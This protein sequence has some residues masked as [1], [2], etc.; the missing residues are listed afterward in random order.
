MM[1]SY[2][3]ESLAPLV[4]RFG[5]PFGSQSSAQDVIFPLPSAGAGLVRATAIAQKKVDFDKNRCGIDDPDYQKV[6]GIKG[7]GIY[8]A[9]VNQNS[10]DILVPKP[11]NALYVEDKEQK[12]KID[13]VRLAPADIEPDCGSDLPN[14]LRYVQTVDN[15][16]KPITIKGKPKSGV[17]YWH[18]DDLIK[19]QNNKPLT[20]D[21][22]KN[23]GLVSIPT[24]IRTH[25]AIDDDT[26]S[27]QEGMLFQTASFDLSYQ[28]KDKEKDKGFDEHRLG[29]VILSEQALD[30]DMVT[31]G[32]ERRLSYFKSIKN[33]SDF[34]KPNQ[35][36]LDSI[37]QAG[38]FSLTF[39]TP[40]VFA[41]GYLPNWI[42]ESAM[43][44]TVPDSK[45]KVQLKA[46]A[47]ERFQAVS[48]WD[49]LL[50]Q[51]KAT[52]KAVPAG[53][54]Y[55]F[56]LTDKLD[57]PTLGRLCQSLADDRYDQNDGF[58]MALITPFSF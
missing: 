37:N 42:D 19:W 10:I 1:N 55:W 30:D 54:V 34:I 16:G 17:N 29:F 8:L 39:L 22:I 9:R 15:N 48:G 57:M 44:S 38:G 41:K 32:G 20:Y 27:S 11:A 53:S 40:C 3:I 24:D 49:S 58:G 45:V 46:V 5:K 28:Q 7:Q 36:L 12:G 14:G 35:A 26:G 51:P 2:L 21:D 33:S 50:W 31:F 13:L 56:G 18:I 25:V 4:F 43:T 52:R 47:V 6:L 23:N